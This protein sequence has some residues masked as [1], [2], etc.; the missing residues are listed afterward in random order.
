MPSVVEAALLPR[1]VGA[2]RA[3]WLVMTGEP[4]D[5]QTAQAWGLVEELA[6]AAALDDRVGQLLERLVA[7]DA[8]ALAQ[9]KTL[10]RLWQEAPLSEAVAASIG[11]YARAYEA[12]GP[13]RRL[14]ATISRGRRTKEH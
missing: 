3:A 14:R 8:A 12:G 7:A 1:L 9:Q 10:L 11:M 2:G 5:A 4:I 13:N 6:P